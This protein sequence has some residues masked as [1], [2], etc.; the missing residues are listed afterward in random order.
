[1]TVR[2]LSATCVTVCLLWLIGC[3]GGEQA[4]SAAETQAETQ[5]QSAE[6]AAAGGEVDASLAG[7]GEQLMTAKGCTA[8]HTVGG[9]RLV[10]PDLLGVT[11]RRE[12]KWIIAMITK[13]DSM[14][15]NDATA[16]QLLGEYYTPMA[17]QGVTEEDA[18]ALLSYLHSKDSQ[19]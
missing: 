10:G 5:A 4:G 15:A 12:D 2:A 9:G 6:A 1:M 11:Q 8:C 16:K 17:N 19:Q 14:L 13:P 3:G 18:R 7:T